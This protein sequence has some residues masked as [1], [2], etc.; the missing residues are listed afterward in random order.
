MDDYRQRSVDSRTE[1]ASPIIKELALRVLK[2]NIDVPISLK[3]LRE[4]ISDQTQTRFSSGSYSGAM[5]DLVEENNG[6]VVN[7]DRGKYMYVS[8]AKQYAINAVL[9]ETIVKLESLAIDNILLLSERDFETIRDIPEL[10]E[11]I[12]RLKYRF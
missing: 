12:E 7:N 8:N 11:R 4:Y 10:V 9:D 6:R 3:D 1:V 5:R 2:D